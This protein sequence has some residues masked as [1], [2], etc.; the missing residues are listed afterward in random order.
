MGSSWHNASFYCKVVPISALLAVFLVFA[1]YILWSIHLFNPVPLRIQMDCSLFLGAE[2]RQHLE[3]YKR[4]RTVLKQK[5]DLG[6]SRCW[7]IRKRRYL[8]TD[9]PDSMEVH[10]NMY[11][12]RIVSQNYDFLEEV[13]TMMYSPLHFYCFVIDSSASAHFEKLVRTLGQ[14]IMNIIVPPGLYDT[15]TAHGTFSAINACYAGMDEFPWQHTI[16]SAEN[17]IPIHSVHYIADNARRL[18]DAARI[19][20]VTISEEHTRILGDDLSK[21]NHQDRGRPLSLDFDKSV[22]LDA[23]HTNRYDNRSNC[24]VGMEDYEYTTNMEPYSC[25]EVTQAPIP[26]HYHLHRLLKS[27]YG[28][29]QGLHDL[30][31]GV[32]TKCSCLAALEELTG[33]EDCNFL[34]SDMIWETGTGPSRAILKVSNPLEAKCDENIDFQI[35]LCR[36]LNEKGIPCPTTIKRLDGRDWARE[37]IV[38]GVHLPVRLFEVIPGSNLENFTYDYEVAKHIGELLAR[39]HII[40]DESKCLIHSD[41]NET[42]V[43]MIEKDGQKKD[44]TFYCAVFAFIG[45]TKTRELHHEERQKKSAIDDNWV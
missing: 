45:Q 35:K 6:P 24:I 1:A 14:C 28:I 23:C 12:L 41:I 31:I 15:S 10:H 3:E 43:L 22:A 34:L 39:F 13:L 5:I 8:P 30:S 18:G 29:N 4:N 7:T 33:Y 36:I 11:F 16:I 32:V 25:D 42:N 40:A 27:S 20:R 19:G 44:V 38:D 21:T 26:E 17:E 37:E 9:V 2:G